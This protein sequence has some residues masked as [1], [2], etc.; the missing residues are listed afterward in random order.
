MQP[1]SKPYKFMHMQAARIVLGVCLVVGFLTAGC[2]GLLDVDPKQSI[3]DEAA[4]ATARGVET[5][6]VG[7]YDILG[8]ENLFGG[9]T[10]LL[11]DL[12]ADDGDVNWSGTFVQPREFHLKT[13]LVNNA[14]STLQWTNAY[15]GINIAN[16]VLSALDVIEDEGRRDRVEGEALF[17]RGLLHFQLVRLYGRP[18][19][20]GD[21]AS[22]LGVPLATEPTRAIG[23]EQRVPRNTVAEVYAQVEADLIAA[24][25]LLPQANGFFAT[26]HAASAI[27]ARVYLEQE[28]WEL[29]AAEADRVIQSGRFALAANYADAFANV[30]N[31]AEY[32]FAMQITPQDGD[33]SLNEFYGTAPGRGDIDMTARHMQR[34]EAGD[35]RADHFYVD[36]DGYVRTEKWATGPSAGTNIPVVRLAEMYLVR[37]EANLRA[38]TQIG[39][40]PVDDVNRIR[41][42]AQLDPLET[43]TVSDVLRERRV[44]LAFEGHRLYDARRNREM[45]GSLPW[46]HQ[47]LVYPIPQREIDANPSLVQNPGYGGS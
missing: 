25:D 17:I 47:R 6:L 27:L 4:L 35:A 15:T 18:Y 11:P 30:E 13:I 37:A 22:N 1:I 32:V 46:N 23:D 8:N 36:S 21:P 19:A 5:A 24:R 28:R 2:D 7:A 38:G 3:A 20:D 41:E 14:F 44:E 33:N 39:A 26:T 31:N 29:A 12:L 9:R 43:V 16:N 45:I 34:Y 10:M 42:R 40:A